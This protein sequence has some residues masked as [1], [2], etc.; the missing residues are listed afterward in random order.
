MLI[1]FP[2][3]ARSRVPRLFLNIEAFILV[4]MLGSPLNSVA[5]GQDPSSSIFS[6]SGF[7]T[8][9][10]VHSSQDRAD[11]TANALVPN[12]AGFTHDWSPD[13]DSRLGAQVIAH[14]TP[15]LSAMLQVI[16]EQRY[17][18]TF[19]PHVEWA[20]INYQ[21][22]PD[23]S[24]RL[25][26]IVLP[27]FLLSDT[28]KVGYANPWLRP[29]VE[30]YGLL[31][32]FDSDGADV[33]YKMHFGEAVNTL[34]GTYGKTNSEVPQGGT[35][36]V[37]RLWVIA[38]NVEYG[39]LNLHIAY[40]AASFTFS[41]LDS[42]FDGFGQFGPQGTALAIKY[43]LDNK[44]SQVFTAG[45]MYDPGKWFATG[46]WGRRNLHSAVGESTAW[47]LSAGYRLAKF[48]PYLTYAD[49]KSDS[50]TFDP[51]LNVSELPPFL[52]GPAAALNAGL[53]TI[54]A[55]AAVQNTISVGSR[56]DVMKNVDLKAQYDHIELGSGS[57]GTLVNLQPGFQRGGHANLIS[58]AIDFVW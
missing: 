23:F 39:A 46:E 24:I 26:R 48:T 53:N 13:V 10:V 43:D 18:K 55:T 40:Q 52:A 30:L 54:L 58:I 51:G 29:P 45:A 57:A 11:Y 15:Q 37:R 25:G 21:A 19:K 4:A 33:N 42:L 6:F 35:Y 1:Q 16:S 44:P 2:Q 17:D 56:W 28:R 9:G 36:N 12:G 7:G 34:I 3:R 32:I 50:R 20:N 31:P 14:F 47:Y 27:T 49:V 41:K 8:L 38:D 22:S 5:A